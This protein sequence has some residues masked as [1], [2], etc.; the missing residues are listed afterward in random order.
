LRF[1]RKKTAAPKAFFHRLRGNGP[2]ALIF[3]AMAA[4]HRFSGA[5]PSWQYID[6]SRY[7]TNPTPTTSS[8]ASCRAEEQG[9]AKQKQKKYIGVIFSKKIQ[10]HEEA[11]TAEQKNRP[12]APGSPNSRDPQRAQGPSQAVK[13]SNARWKQTRP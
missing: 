3:L 6:L 7:F 11:G 12:A 4:R 2:E 13:K 8:M 9:T 1:L 5:D 10:E